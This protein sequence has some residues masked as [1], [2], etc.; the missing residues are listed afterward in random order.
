MDYF[1]DW[2]EWLN[3]DSS[4]AAQDVDVQVV[5]KNVEVVCNNCHILVKCNNC[6]TEFIKDKEDKEDKDKVKPE[7]GDKTEAMTDTKPAV[8]EKED[9]AAASEDSTTPNSST[10]DVEISTEV[11]TEASSTTPPAADNN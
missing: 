9:L 1:N 5:K 4:G 6:T 10:T 3:D 2:V 8:L 11:N 7:L